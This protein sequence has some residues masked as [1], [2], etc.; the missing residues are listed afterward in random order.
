MFPEVVTIE[1]A[2]HYHAAA[3]DRFADEVNVRAVEGDSTALLPTLQDGTPTF[4]WLDGHWSTGD[5][6]GAENQCPVLQEL[7]GLDG[8]SALDCIAID[9]ARLFL[10]RPPAPLDPSQWP[11]IEEVF[12]G[13]HSVRPG[14]D[15]IVCHD[16]V[17]AAP[18]EAR[19]IVDDFALRA[20]GSDRPLPR[21]ALRRLLV[22]WLAALD[23]DA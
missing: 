23:R 20:P 15:V 16:L 3:V 17:V 13:I 8:G 5:T 1:L 18:A 21:R 14:H 22:R 11:T 2:S 19:A 7:A 9:D 4:Y 6:A 12:E 10:A